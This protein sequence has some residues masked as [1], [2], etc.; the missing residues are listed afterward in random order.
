VLVGT[1]DI[2]RP[3]QNSVMLAQMI[4]GAWLVQIQEAGHGVMY[5]Y[6]EKFSKIIET[7]LS[8]IL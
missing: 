8:L 2:V 5:Q 7:F 1:E 6:P 3:P 4:P